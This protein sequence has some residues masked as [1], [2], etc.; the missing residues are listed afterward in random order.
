[1]E[2]ASAAIEITRSSRSSF[3]G[4]KVVCRCLKVTES[5]ICEAVTTCDIQTL[6]DLGNCTGAGQGCT[7]CH[8]R[9]R[10]YLATA[11]GT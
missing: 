3:S 6:Q 7:A 11:S 9:L 2:L 5:E 10:K 4:M 8:I 1:M